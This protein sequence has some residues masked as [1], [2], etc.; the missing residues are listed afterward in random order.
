M[1]KMFMIVHL[2]SL[3]LDNPDLDI[4]EHSGENY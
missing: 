4:L 2:I 1:D 3:D